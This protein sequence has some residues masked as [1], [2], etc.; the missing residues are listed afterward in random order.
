MV[1]EWRHGNM[2]QIQ[3]L[4]QKQMAHFQFDED[5]CVYAVMRVDV[6]MRSKVHF[7]DKLPTI[8]IV[9]LGIFLGSV[10]CAVDGFTL[11]FTVYS[12]LIFFMIMMLAFGQYAIAEG[13]V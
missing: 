9:G 5:N 10:G 13:L 11:G 6:P 12:R 2:Q 3:R 1:R 4:F 8:L 7:Y